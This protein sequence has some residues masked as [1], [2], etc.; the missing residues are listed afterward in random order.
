MRAIRLLLWGIALHPSWLTRLTPKNEQEMAS[1]REQD[2]A[3]QA[4]VETMSTLILK[5]GSP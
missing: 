2:A 5:Q 4:Y 3:V 1:D